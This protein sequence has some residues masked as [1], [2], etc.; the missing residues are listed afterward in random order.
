MKVNYSN[1]RFCVSNLLFYILQK[2]TVTD[3]A[4]FLNMYYNIKF[5]DLNIIVI[6]YRK[7]KCQG[8]IASR[9]MMFILSFVKAHM[10]SDTWT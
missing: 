7:L 5:Q 3:I 6:F 10:I 9:G 1:C 4:V 2:I 8:G